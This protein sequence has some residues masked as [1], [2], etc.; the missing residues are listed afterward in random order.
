MPTATWNEKVVAQSEKFE[1]VEGER[2]LSA[3]VAAE[4]IL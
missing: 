3:G 2:L 4:R 1:T